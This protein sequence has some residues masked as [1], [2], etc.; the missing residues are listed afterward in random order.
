MMQEKSHGRELLL[1][2]QVVRLVRDGQSRRAVVR[3]FKVSKNRYVIG[4]VVSMLVGLIELIGQITGQ[5]N[6]IPLIV[7]IQKLNDVLSSCE[8]ISK[9]KVR[10]ENM[11]RWR[12]NVKWFR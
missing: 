5:P 9:I 2:E 10:W 12:F 7:P 4:V 11:K 1:R 6:A 8:K 3:Q